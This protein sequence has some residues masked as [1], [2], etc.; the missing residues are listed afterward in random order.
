M[1]I[2]NYL[3]NCQ[4]A[5]YMGTPIISDEIFDKLAITY[6]FHEFGHEILETR[7]KHI[8]PMYSLSKIYDDEEYNISFKSKSIKTPKLDG[9][10]IELVYVDGNLISASTRGNGE[11]GED[12]LDKVL[13]LESIPNSFNTSLKLLQITGEIVAPRTI[14]NSRN[15]AAGSLNLKDLSIFKSKDLTF[16]A[17]GTSPYIY[18]LYENDLAFLTMVGFHTVN[19]KGLDKFPTDGIVIRCNDNKEFITLGYTAKHP[20]GA[21]ARKK[22]SDVE[23][24][25]TIL[26]DVIW[27]IGPS[28][29]VTPVAIFNVVNIDDANITRATLHNVGFIEDMDLSIGDTLLVTRSGGVIPKVVGKI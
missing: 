16:I 11:Y 2:Q 6:N 13:L 8:F 18:N 29:K 24:K 3:K 20:R 5:Y 9:A 26:T 1:K 28:G 7:I 19:E 4:E 15:Y 14:E 10:A 23:I 25:E 22:S 17:Y 21:Y 27:Q 12:I